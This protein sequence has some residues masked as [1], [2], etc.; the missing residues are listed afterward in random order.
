MQELVADTKALPWRYMNDRDKVLL[1][2]QIAAQS[3]TVKEEEE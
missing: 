3:R 2:E 1:E